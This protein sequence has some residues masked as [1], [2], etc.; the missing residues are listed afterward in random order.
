VGTKFQRRDPGKV[1]KVYN[2]PSLYS[3]LM[4]VTCS[5]GCFT[6]NL[7]NSNNMPKQILI[8]DLKVQ[9]MLPSGNSGTIID[10]YFGSPNFS[11]KNFSFDVAS[12]TEFQ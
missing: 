10:Q 1:T 4:Q 12:A 11:L 7:L 8:Q 9:K 2:D 5:G 3:S 6:A